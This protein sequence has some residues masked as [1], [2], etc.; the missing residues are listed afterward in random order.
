[1]PDDCQD[2]QSENVSTAKYTFDLTEVAVVLSVCL[3]ATLTGRRRSLHAQQIT[4]R[5]RAPATFR[6]LKI[7][8]IMNTAIRSEL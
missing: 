2:L 4:L 1:M 3:E 7:V 6:C 8:V 5:E